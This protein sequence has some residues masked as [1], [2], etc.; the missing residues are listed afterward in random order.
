MKL[1]QQTCHSGH[2]THPKIQKYLCSKK[3]ICNNKSAQ[4]YVKTKTKMERLSLSSSYKNLTSLVMSTFKWSKVL[5]QHFVHSC[6]TQLKLIYIILKVSTDRHN[7]CMVK[8]YIQILDWIQ[9]KGL[10]Y[11]V[12]RLYMALS[13]VQPRPRGSMLLGMKRHSCYYGIVF[14]KSTCT[15]YKLPY[16]VYKPNAL[17]TLFN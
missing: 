17:K 12:K 16:Y 14:I 2:Q 13:K 3:K 8:A 7:I 5:I 9:I 1:T 15:V 10:I 6:K 11:V 4:G